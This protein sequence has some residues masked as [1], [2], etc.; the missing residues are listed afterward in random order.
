MEGKEL[1]QECLKLMETA[2]V[3]YLSTIAPDGFPQTRA[4]LNL[5]SKKLFPALAKLFRGHDESLLVY[6]TTNTASAKMRQI[7]AN[8]K[9]SLYF[10]DPSRF[11]GLM[12]AGEIETVTE[13]TLKKQLW[14]EDW[15]NYYPGGAD[16]LDYTILRLLPT[17]AKGWNQSAPFEIELK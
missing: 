8:A 3:V 14:Q 9:A 10:C 11:H 5:R 15:K 12:L 6:L 1:K 13:K 16:D 2:E 4:M 7:M 17:F